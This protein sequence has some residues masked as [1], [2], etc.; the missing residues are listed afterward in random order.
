MDSNILLNL[1]WNL[2]LDIQEKA[3]AEIASIVDLNLKDLLQPIGKEYWENAAKVL[4]RIG[5]PKIKGE[6]PGLIIWLE[7]INWPGSTTVMEILGTIPISIL[8]PYLEDAVIEALS[9]D[10]EVW[11]ENLSYFL[12][13]FNLKEDNFKSRDVY[14]ALLKG[15]E[16][17]K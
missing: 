2:P 8:I 11:I 17:W 15:S 10:D 5:Y 1:S 14:L 16:F 12:V 9:T 13:Q 3:V 6:I 7:D 4:F